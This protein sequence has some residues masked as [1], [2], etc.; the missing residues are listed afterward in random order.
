MFVIVGDVE[1]VE[2]MLPEEAWDRPVVADEVQLVGRDEAAVEEASRR[3]L[4]VHGVFAGEPDQVWATGQ[5]VVGVEL[6]LLVDADRRA[7]VV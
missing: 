3:G 1:A 2:F 7:A 6:I 5:P 4:G